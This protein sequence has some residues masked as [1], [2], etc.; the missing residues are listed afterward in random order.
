MP[1]TRISA[2]IVTYNRLDQLR[3]AIQNTLALQFTNIVVIDNASTD[4]TEQ[5]LKSFVD[6][7][8]IVVREQ[9]NGGGAGGFAKGFE[10]AVT[11][12]DADWL[13][14]FDDDAYP[15]KNALEMFFALSLGKDV[16]GVAA[17]VYFAD[18]RICPMNRPGE[19]MFRS[20]TK[21]SKVIA[22]KSLSAG[23]GYD[24]YQQDRLVEIGF[25]SF[26]GLFVRCDLVRTVI[27]LPRS[28][29]FVYRDD[30]L[31]TLALT[32]RGYKLI[33]APNVRFIH[34]CEVPSTSFRVYTP[35][36]KVY[37]I[38][39][40]EIP[41]F[42][43]L[44]GIWFYLILPVLLARWLMPV[45]SYTKPHIYFR[46]AFTAI[47]DGLRDDFSK[48]HEQVLAMS[49]KNGVTSRSDRTSNESVVRQ[50]RSE[51]L[52]LPPTASKRSR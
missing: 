22:K 35:F 43:E 18:G 20:L 19:D 12:T 13:V 46:F 24:V 7:R 42:K 28:K 39:R 52:S 48:T 33:F 49:Q 21:L 15:D 44:Y 23:V 29:L 45:F 40:N 8:L 26:V 34:N 50:A 36:W 4:G 11:K 10:I 31:Y 38:I 27:G 47:I 14:C 41:F 32:R 16:A 2:V 37:Y 1:A 30:S 5:Y 6:P 51:G 3:A 17:A 25:S 9:V